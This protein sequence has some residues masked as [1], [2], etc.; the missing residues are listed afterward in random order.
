MYYIYETLPN[1]YV[2][3]IDNLRICFNLHYKYNDFIE[4]LKL[5]ENAELNDLICKYY[6]STKYYSF[7]H[8]YTISSK[9]DKISFTIGFSKEGNHNFE[10]DGF[11]DFNPNKVGEWFYFTEFY[12]EFI[13]YASDLKLRR[14]DLAIDLPFKRSDVKLIK[15]RRSYHFLKDR[16][17]T[18]YLGKRSNHNF[19][20]LYDKT[21]ESKLDYDLTRLEITVDAD[22][23]IQFPEVKIKALTTGKT[24]SE[25]S[26]TENVLLQLLDLAG[27]PYYY[28]NQL[29]RVLK[30]KMKDYLSVDYIDFEFEAIYLYKLLDKV[31]DKFIK[32]NIET[33]WQFVAG[34]DLPWEV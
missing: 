32:G 20:K 11:I 15:D 18:E 31:N 33:S 3:S 6:H 27:D 5:V 2:Y 12:Q 29:S 14:Y 23:E 30:T 4:F 24:F 21:V 1:N 7:E 25:L 16:S 17:I 28:V 34:Y 22:H 9:K 13:K 19:I 8:L 26:A 10:F